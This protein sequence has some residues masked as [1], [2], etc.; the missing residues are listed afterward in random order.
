MLLAVG[1]YSSKTDEFLSFYCSRVSGG[2]IRVRM[3]YT[4]S[5]GVG[6]PDVECR[7]VPEV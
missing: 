5:V 7:F 4:D 2:R 1:T 3:T 6:L